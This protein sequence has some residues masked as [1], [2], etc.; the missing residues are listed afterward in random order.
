VYLSKEV[1]RGHFFLSDRLEY[2]RLY[3][4]YPRL[5]FTVIRSPEE[6]L[7]SSLWH[8]V[9]HANNLIVGRDHPA[10]EF[11]KY[12]RAIVAEAASFR[13]NNTGMQLSFFLHVPHR[14]RLWAWERKKDIAATAEN[15]ETR[16]YAAN[17]V[18][19]HGMACAKTTFQCA[20]ERRGTAANG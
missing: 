15:L 5:F 12:R 8:G 9:R 6:Q 11:S 17:P 7:M 19:A 18:V 14:R 20:S 3:H 13:K 1:I 2:A 4:K 10:P 16:G